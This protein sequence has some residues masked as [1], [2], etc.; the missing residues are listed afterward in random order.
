MTRH[1]LQT[2]CLHLFFLYSNTELTNEFFAPEN[3]VGAFNVKTTGELGD[4]GAK[5]E[6]II[7][8]NIPDSL[9]YNLTPL[10]YNGAAQSKLEIVTDNFNIKN[11]NKITITNSLFST[12]TN[13][14]GVGST[15]FNYTLEETPERLL[16]PNNEFHN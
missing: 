12:S 8:R 14:S 1:W 10:N 3:N 6:L 11:P 15:T 9:Y 5:L 2:L 13:V 7:D 4:A 16:Y